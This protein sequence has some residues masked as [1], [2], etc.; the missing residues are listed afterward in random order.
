MAQSGF[1]TRQLPS[2]NF[3]ESCGAILFDLADPATKKVC[4]VNYLKTNEWLLPKGR[5]NFAEQRKEAA[6]REIIEETGY[7]CHIHPVTMP[8]RALKQDGPDV[9]QVLPGATEPFM[10]TIR[11]LKDGASVKFIYW[12]IAALDEEARGSRGAGEP[13]FVPEFF[14][15]SDAVDKLQFQSDRDV[16]SRAIQLVT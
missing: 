15:L 3:V 2:E 12:Y 8:T 1:V 11:D 5:R 4:L 6:I 14:A 9:A 7:R 16:L 13:Q 10:V